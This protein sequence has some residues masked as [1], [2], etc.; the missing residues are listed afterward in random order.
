M[1]ST[2]SAL[3]VELRSNEGSGI[4]E[5]GR[6]RGREEGREGGNDRKREKGRK[7]RRERE[8]LTMEGRGREK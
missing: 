7:G 1:V 2:G 6:E 4:R 3:S 5:G 8:I